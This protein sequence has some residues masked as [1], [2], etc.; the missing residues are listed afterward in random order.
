MIPSQ[1]KTNYLQFRKVIL[2]SLF[3]FFQNLKKKLRPPHMITD[4]FYSYT[5]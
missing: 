2:F 5:P 4:I 1:F 3:R